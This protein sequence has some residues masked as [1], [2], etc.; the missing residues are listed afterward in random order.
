MTFVAIGT[1]HA[2]AASASS[3]SLTP[4]A[5]TGAFYCAVYAF[6]G[7]AA[8]SG[9][10]VKPWTTGDPNNVIGPHTGWLQILFQAPSGIGVGIEVW[11]AINSGSGPRVAN[12]VSSST[13]QA[14]I[15]AY[16]GAYAP[17]GTILDG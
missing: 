8:G 2:Y 15:S 4:P 1:D 7:V 12:F 17:T 10:W 14:V 5:T 13:C 16:T 6:S 11:C 9:P 3:V